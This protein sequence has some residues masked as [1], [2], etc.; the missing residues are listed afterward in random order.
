MIPGSRCVR[1]IVLLWRCYASNLK[2]FALVA[3]FAVEDSFQGIPDSFF[4]LVAGTLLLCL[5]R[6]R[7]SCGSG[8]VFFLAAT[9]KDIQQTSYA[10]VVFIRFD[11]FSCFVHAES[12]VYAIVGVDEGCYGRDTLHVQKLG[13]GIDQ[14]F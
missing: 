1:W 5:G 2:L 9:F 6:R 13:Y 14:G 12:D 10:I 3:P 11:G 8:G 7:R 4:D